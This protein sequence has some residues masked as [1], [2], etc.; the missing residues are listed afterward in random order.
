VCFT[1]RLSVEVTAFADRGSI[2]VQTEM[3]ER[4][5]SSSQTPYRSLP[6]KAESSLILL[7][8]LSTADPLRWALPGPEAAFGNKGAHVSFI[9]CLWSALRTVFCPPRSQPS[10][11]RRERPTAVALR[12]R[13]LGVPCCRLRAGTPFVRACALPPPSER[14]AIRLLDQGA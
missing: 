6:A 3:E 2:S 13:P 9:F 12:S 10:R 1:E 5:T 7:L 4:E 14:E 11:L 8:V